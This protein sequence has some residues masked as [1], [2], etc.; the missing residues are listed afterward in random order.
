MKLAEAFIELLISAMPISSE[1]I[2]CSS[3][4]GHELPGGI[5]IVD[6]LRK[7]VRDSRVFVALIT[8]ESFKSTYVQFEMGA[9]WGAGLRLIPL[10][11][12]MKVDDLIQGPLGML[13]CLSCDKEADLLR[14]VE[15]IS[16]ELGLTRKEPSLYQ[17]YIA[18]LRELANQEVRRHLSLTRPSGYKP[19]DPGIED[20]KR[21]LRDAL[22]FQNRRRDWQNISTV[23]SRARMSEDEALALLRSMSDVSLTIGADGRRI[24]KRKNR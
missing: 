14:L 23:A 17:R 11:V 13:R 22:K 18:R 5:S 10:L 16:V 8:P 7:E 19:P 3:V 2:R 4:P 1:R 9:R 20:K 12:A 15:Q 6:V 21:R 24:A